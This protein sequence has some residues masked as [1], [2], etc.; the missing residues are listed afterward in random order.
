[1][2]LGALVEAIAS[3]TSIRKVLAAQLAT[4]EEMAFLTSE[5]WMRGSRMPEI[6]TREEVLISAAKLVRPREIDSNAQLNFEIGK[7][8]HHQLQEVLLP[9]IGVLLG[10]WECTQCG[11]HYGVKKPWQKVGEYAVRRPE[12]CRCE[13]NTFRF[14][15]YSFFD[16]EYRITGHPDGILTIPG[17]PGLGILEAKSISEK[18]AWEI[19]NVPKLDHVIQAH[20]Y[21]WFTGLQWAKILYWDKSVYGLAGLVEHTVDRNEETIDAIKATLVELWAGVASGIAPTSRVC[22]G[23]DAPRA[24]K[25]LVNGPCFTSGMNPST[26]EQC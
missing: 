5:S 18:G 9:S 11:A 12:Q 7:A 24:K 4:V 25:C 14:H 17:L 3:S 10:E 21:M 26:E 15:E 2:A 22:A 19:T 6:C 1:M 8:L 20:I 23:P 16:A 13:N